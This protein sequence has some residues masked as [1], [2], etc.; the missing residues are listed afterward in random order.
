MKV[1]DEGADFKQLIL[2]D[3]DIRSNLS[4]EEVERAFDLDDKLRHVEKV[5][6]R[7]FG[8]G[9]GFREDGE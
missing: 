2:E 3:P 8:E 1:W 4:P 6:R 5:F 7:V 9:S